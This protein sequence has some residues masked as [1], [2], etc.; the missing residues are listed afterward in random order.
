MLHVGHE[1]HLLTDEQHINR[2]EIKVVEE[3]KRSEPVVGRMLAGIQ[4]VYKSSA[5]VSDS[6]ET[7]RCRTITVLP[8][9]WTMWHD[10]PTSFPP[11]RQRNMSSSAGST[12]SSGA[13]EA[14]AEALR[15]DAILMLLRLLRPRNLR[16]RGQPRHAISYMRHAKIPLQ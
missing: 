9:Y 6:K 14:M 5:T 1:C 15:L 3:R 8:L 10:R 11:P 12:G 4:L 13:A 2:A 16:G 7:E